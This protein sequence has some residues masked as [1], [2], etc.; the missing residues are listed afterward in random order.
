MPTEP[1]T[2]AELEA[3]GRAI[4]RNTYDDLGALFA[5]RWTVIMARIRAQD[6]RIEALEGALEGSLA[7]QV[8]STI[9]GAKRILE[10]QGLLAEAREYVEG[11]CYT[12]DLVGRIDAALPAQQ[13]GKD[14]EQ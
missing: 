11:A 13:S 3:M 5:S 1:I 4:A 7:V 14:A 9:S 12:D 8:D 10:L 2:D 6:E